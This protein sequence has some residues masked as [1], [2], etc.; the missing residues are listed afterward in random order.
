MRTAHT[1]YV[2]AVLAHTASARS[3]HL[4]KHTRLWKVHK[5][6]TRLVPELRGMNF[7]GT[8]R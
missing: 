4:S 8:L 5:H 2:T 3:P 6:A 7:E 1:K